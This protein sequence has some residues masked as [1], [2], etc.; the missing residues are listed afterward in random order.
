MIEYL[1]NGIND[2]INEELEKRSEDVKRCVDNHGGKALTSTK[3]KSTETVCA[4]Y[5]ELG[6]FATKELHS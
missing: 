3:A 2:G 1:R 5:D 4:K 6:A